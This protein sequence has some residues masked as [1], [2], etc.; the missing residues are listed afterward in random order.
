MKKILLALTTVFC[1]VTGSAAWAADA[2][3]PAVERTRQ[4]V[5]MLDDLYKTVIVLVTEHYV[6]DPSTLSAA[7][8]GKAI[9]AAMKQKGWH[10]V[11]LVGF[12][13]VIYKPENKPA[14]AFE[15]AAKKNLTAGKATH[16][17]V[18][19]K[20]GKRYLRMATAVP[21]VM[22]KCVMCHANFKNNKN[23]IGALAYTVPL[24]K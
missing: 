3:D 7:T 17:E 8:A 12:T 21:V 20:D 9:F 24:V 10:D 6:K 4:Q 23:V 19:T 22:E 15:E 2:K 13:D 11:R 16:E 18:V 5:L 14:D 1:A